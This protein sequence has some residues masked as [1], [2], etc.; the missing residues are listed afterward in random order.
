M[1]E[2]GVKSLPEVEE[3]F[4]I[5]LV[6]EAVG[7]S[8]MAASMAST[9]ASPVAPALVANLVFAKRF[10]LCLKSILLTMVYLSSC[11]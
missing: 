3:N 10:L 7:E 6:V 5:A 4:G 2:L 1:I 9:I 8:T 11:P